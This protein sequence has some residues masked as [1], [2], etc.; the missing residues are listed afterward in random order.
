MTNKFDY[1]GIPAINK[2]LY[3]PVI[4]T[5][6]LASLFILFV[7][8]TPVFWAALSEF[9]EIRRFLLI[10]GMLIF[11]ISSLGCAV[12]NN[13]WGMVVLR[14]TQSIGSSAGQSIGGGIISD[15]FPIEQRGTAYGKFFLGQNIGPVI[16][17]AHFS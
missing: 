12:I 11:T 16:G 17:N 7:G 2:E 6:L 4:A 13:I 5:T 8:V 9:Y 10:L 14:C 3:A 1:P 15:L